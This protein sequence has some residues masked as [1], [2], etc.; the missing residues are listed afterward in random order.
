M[1]KASPSSFRRSSFNKQEWE[2]KLK[3]VKISRSEMNEIVLNY[4][5]VE[6]YEEAAQ[7]FQQET[8][9]D[10]KPSNLCS[11][12]ERVGI[13]KKMINGDIAGAIEQVNDLNPNILD[14]NP[15]LYFKLQQQQLIELIKDGKIDEAL[16]FAQ[17]ELAPLVGDNTEF[18]QEIE[19]AMSL[20][21]FENNEQS[22][23]ANLLTSG[24]RQK[25]A[26]ELNSAILS[27]Q[28]EETEPQL[29][30][31]L[32]KLIFG[33]T[34]LQEKV[35]YPKIVDILKAEFEQTESTSNSQNLSSQEESLS[36]EMEED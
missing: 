34:R 17:E 5:I 2:Q 21:A 8:N 1:S 4:L 10:N 33:Q 31:L 20:L 36:D 22:P 14:S 28:H 26:S 7:I 13:R 35:S 6:G 3:E 32:R 18:L 19:K 27:A 30:K 9:L 24:Q 15:K 23:F 11:I 25:T 29:Q 12:N 16:Q